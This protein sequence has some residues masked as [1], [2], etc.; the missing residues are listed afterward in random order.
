MK[1]HKKYI[2]FI[3][4]QLSELGLKVPKGMSDRD[5][6]WVLNSTPFFRFPKK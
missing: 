6:W 2:R 5:L 1:E 4:R 3:K